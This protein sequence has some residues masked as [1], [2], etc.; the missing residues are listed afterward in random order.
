MRS[1]ESAAIE[2]VLQRCER[3]TNKMTA[4]TSMNRRIIIIS[5]DPIDLVGIN[6]EIPR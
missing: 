5:L 2:T 3:F 6:Y 1:Y 4:L